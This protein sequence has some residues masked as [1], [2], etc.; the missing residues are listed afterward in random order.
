MMKKPLIVE[1]EDAP[2]SPAEA[3]PVIDIPDPATA[4]AEQLQGRAMQIAARLA[5]RPG[6]KI[7][8]FFWWAAGTLVGFLV[9]VAAWR[10]V[11]GLM[12][13]NPVLGWVAT[14]LFGLFILAALLLA[15]R[16]V[17][18]FARLAKLDHVHRAVNEAI[19]AD[20]LNRARKVADQVAGLYATR[21]EMA[22]VRDRLKERAPE[23]LDT[24]T[25]LVLAESELM[26][27]LDAAAR[28]EIEAAVRTVATVTALVPLA[29]ADVFAALTANLR[30]IRRVAEIYGGRAGTLGSIRLARV[31]MTH[32]VATG[33][34]AAGDDLIETVT[35]GHLFAKLSRRFGEGVV[36]GALTAR[37]GVAAMEVCRPM[38]FRVLPKPRVTNLTGR[39]LAGVFSRAKAPDPDE[40]R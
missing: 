32:L 28:L 10:F 6:S 1:F 39:A 17:S 25:L 36:N 11:E 12:V 30:M 9:S 21:P 24:Q 19:E 35:G 26:T 18:A 8:R 15:G 4:T 14:V 3:P 34:V 16:E 22:W 31:V 23:Q 29:L 38:P 5:A 33:A 13:A 7:G 20:D 40:A 2:A 37:V 27:P